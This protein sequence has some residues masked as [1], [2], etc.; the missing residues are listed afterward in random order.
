[1]EDITPGGPA[2]KVGIKN[3]D[4]IRKLDGQ[5]VL[6]SGQLTAAV[7]TT[8]PGTQVTL[9]ILRDG[10]PMT[11]KVTLGERPAN[12]TASNAP[13]GKESGPSSGTLR[14]MSIQ[15]LTPT[16][17]DQLNLPSGTKGVVISDL[18]PNSPGAQSGLQ[19]GDV[20]QSV[21]REPVNSVAEF[22]R[23]AGQAKGR[24]LL[25][26][27]RPG[28]GGAFVVVAPIDTGGGD[29]GGDQGDENQ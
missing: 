3:G 29:N 16:V 27:Y 23:L 1:V 8:N 19:T 9:D 14:G 21:N 28:Q 20:I 10:K 25:R 12:V 2:D 4:V 17:R 6:D 15:N 22:N 7:T 18:D 11:V 26:V 13:G 5:P 24:T